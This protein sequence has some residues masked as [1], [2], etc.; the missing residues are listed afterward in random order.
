MDGTRPRAIGYE[1]LRVFQLTIADRWL[2]R[3]EKSRDRFAQFF[4]YFSGFNALYFLW[5]VADNLPE[6]KDDRPVG[7]RDHIAN[8]LRKLDHDDAKRIL[9]EAAGSVAFFIK[10]PIQRMDRQTAQAPG[11]GDPGEG[12][13]LRRQLANTN[14]A[15]VDRVVALGRILYLVRCNLVHGSKADSGDDGEVIAQAVPAL[16]SLLAASMELT[17]RRDR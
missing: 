2:E 11:Q 10:R 6:H 16:R 5:K 4:F 17:R 12:S 14:A 9:D 13:W 3:G 15:P 8:L 1:D 7:E